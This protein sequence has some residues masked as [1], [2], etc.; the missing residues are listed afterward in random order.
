MEWLKVYTGRPNPG[1]VTPGLPVVAGFLPPGVPAPG[2][3]SCRIS[4]RRPGV[5]SCVPAERFERACC[6]LRI[7]FHASIGDMKRGEAQVLRLRQR[8]QG[9]IVGGYSVVLLAAGSGP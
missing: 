1:L 5:R 2:G 4:R 8:V 7:H 3:S 6:P 9:E